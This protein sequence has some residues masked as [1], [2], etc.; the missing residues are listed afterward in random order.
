MRFL[1]YK[2]PA[3]NAI[4][5][6]I[7]EIKCYDSLTDPWVPASCACSATA[8]TM[9]RVAAYPAKIDASDS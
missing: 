6:S 1:A 7:P 5:D 4:V 2:T 8:T 3:L 9:L